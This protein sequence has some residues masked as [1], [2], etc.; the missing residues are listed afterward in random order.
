MSLDP[1]GFIPM[2]LFQK[3]LTLPALEKLGKRKRK[4]RLVI[5]APND[6]MYVCACE[7]PYVCVC[8]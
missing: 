3:H 8:V 5:S 6:S 2:V 1:A 7:G 4:T